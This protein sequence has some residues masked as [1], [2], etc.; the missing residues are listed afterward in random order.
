VDASGNL[1]V[2][3][4]YNHAIRRITPDGTVTTL[5]GNTGSAGNQDGTGT[6][7]YFNR[8]TGITIDA[9]GNIYLADTGN[10][11]IRKVT[12]TGVVT[13]LTGSVQP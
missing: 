2:A 9:S 6:R 4:T 13:T 12:S 3:D 11:L 5:A 7:A 1:L 10:G 8:P